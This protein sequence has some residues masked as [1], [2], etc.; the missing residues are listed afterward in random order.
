M[1]QNFA[2]V[3][4]DQQYIH[5]DPVR[6]AASPF[7]GPIA[8]GFLTLSLL[9]HLR[10]L[11]PELQTSDIRMGINYGFDKIRFI[12]PVRAGGRIRA[13]WSPISV[14]AK[15]NDTYDIRDNVEIEIAGES[16]PALAAV[17]IARV[18]V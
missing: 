8:H 14:E 13:R 5:V 18:I 6:A 1:I 9:S 12:N 4:R 17:W 3:T 16:K 7:G 10:D 15:G 11:T 2:D